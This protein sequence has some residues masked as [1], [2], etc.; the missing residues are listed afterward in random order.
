MDDYSAL[1]SNI[2]DPLVGSI[3]NLTSMSEHWNDQKWSEHQQTKQNEFAESQ[4]HAIQQYNTAERE[5]SQA[6]QKWMWDNQNAYNSPIQQMQRMV[7]AGI[8]PNAAAGFVAGHNVSAS[9]PASIAQSSSPVSA[10]SAPSNSGFA[11]FGSQFASVVEAQAASRLSHSQARLNDTMAEKTQ[12]ETKGI[13][14][15]NN[16]KP[17]EKD[18]NIGLARQKID[19]MEKQGELTH[20]QAVQI[21]DMLDLLKT[22]TIAE[23]QNLFNNASY[24]AQRKTN[25]V[26][27]KK[28][29]EEQIKTEYSKRK[30]MDAAAYEAYM[31]GLEHNSVIEVNGKRVSVEAAEARLKIIE[32]NIKKSD[33]VWRNVLRSANIDPDSHGASRLIDMG[34]EGLRG[35][36]LRVRSLMNSD[37]IQLNSYSWDDM[38][39]PKDIED[40]LRDSE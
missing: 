40:A 28:F 16:Y 36:K 3:W 22:K 13:V 12:E 5:A 17:F 37:D 1:W 32:G 7:A 6:W 11:P 21:R 38:P 18:A 19:L 24:I 35:L 33:N 4:R 25:L 2:S 29:I 27:E 39:I 9:V 15:D 31:S 23:T 30:Q 26:S 8:N 20:E 34:A 14:I 10:G